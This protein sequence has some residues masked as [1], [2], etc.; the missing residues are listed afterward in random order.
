MPRCKLNTS[1]TITYQLYYCSA[2]VAE[3]LL[4]TNAASFKH[5]RTFETIWSQT[6]MK[7]E[8]SSGLRKIL[9][10]PDEHLR[11]LADLGQPVEHWVSL[12]V[13]WLAEK[14]GR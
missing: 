6:S 5:I 8:A 4:K 2:T 3:N 9:E 11:A 10:T 13:F 12:L 1:I 7:V 14:N